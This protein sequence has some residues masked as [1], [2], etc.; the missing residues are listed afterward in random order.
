MKIQLRK[1][2][3][4]VVASALLSGQALAQDIVHTAEKAGQFKTLLTAVKAAGLTS[5]LKGNGPFTVFAPT[6]EAFSKLG[7]TVQDLLKP[8]NR[9]TLKAI[10]TYHVLPNEVLAARVGRLK[11]GTKVRT[12]N[13]ATLTIRNRGQ[14]K[15]NNSNILKT[16]VLADNGVIHVIDAVL[17]P[18]KKEHSEEARSTRCDG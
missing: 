16:D 9:E 17:L 8:E 6:D 15:V 1:S 11:D 2:V 14:L 18:P 13:G 3:L 12:V 4:L 5:V 10:L 7:H